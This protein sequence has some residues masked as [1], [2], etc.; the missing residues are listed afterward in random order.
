MED[1]EYYEN[2]PQD[3]YYYDEEWYDEYYEYDTRE[4]MM[5]TLFSDGANLN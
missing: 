4:N 1:D 3:T 2:D 5:D